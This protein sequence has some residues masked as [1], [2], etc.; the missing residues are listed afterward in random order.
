MA[1]M[2]CEL[3]SPGFIELPRCYAEGTGAGVDKSDTDMVA[4]HWISAAEL[5]KACRRR[6]NAKLS[7]WGLPSIVSQLPQPQPQHQQHLI[8]QNSFISNHVVGG[9]PRGPFGHGG[10]GAGY[11]PPT[12]APPVSLPLARQ[13]PLQL[14]LPPQSQPPG[15]Y[16]QPLSQPPPQQRPGPVAV[17]IY[18]MLKNMVTDKVF[19]IF[20]ENL[21]TTGVSNQPHPSASSRA[22]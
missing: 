3:T 14:P 19:S 22:R 1:I 13:L 7:V 5:H 12:G 20:F 9:G 6:S 2:A 4:L 16:P 15:M 8:H 17:D 10:P 21:A 11:G 18:P